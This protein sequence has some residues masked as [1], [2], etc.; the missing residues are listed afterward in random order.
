MEETI[1][2]PKDRVAVLIGEKGSTKR[3]IQRKTKTKLEINS[4]E[5][6]VKV[7]GEDSLNVFLT[8][9]VV[10]AVGRGF[11]PD[12][13]L[14]LLK[15]NYQMEI[16]NI[17]DYCRTTRNDQ[18]RVKS[19]IIGKRGK[20]RTTLENMTNTNISIYGKTVSIIGPTENVFLAKRAV[21]KLLQGTPHGNLYKWIEL[22]K[23]LE[24][25]NLK[26]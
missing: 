21:E 16:I 10:K 4:Q 8:V 6:D 5:G 20:A 7:E 25:D 23:E 24:K 3:D 9:Q 26:Q 17:K 2:I 18:E 1:K 11:N 13:A 22:Q 12:I 19:R 14:I 15:E